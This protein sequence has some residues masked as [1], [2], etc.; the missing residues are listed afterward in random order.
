MN[1]KIVKGVLASVANATLPKTA[2]AVVA[3]IETMIDSERLGSARPKVLKRLS[4]ALAAVKM[5]ARDAAWKWQST[6][7]R[8]I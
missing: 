1:R 3:L 7:V 6:I 2:G 5:A 4:E 8:D